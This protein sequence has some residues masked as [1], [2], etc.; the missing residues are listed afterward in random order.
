MPMPKPFQLKEGEALPP[1]IYNL[2]QNIQK[3]NFPIHNS[4]LVQ[5]IPLDVKLVGRLPAYD[6]EYEDNEHSFAISEHD[7]NRKLLPL[8]GKPSAIC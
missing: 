5:P 2:P 6:V 8:F 3:V 4:R 1:R 7:K